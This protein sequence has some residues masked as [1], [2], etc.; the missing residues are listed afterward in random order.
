MAKPGRPRE[1]LSKISRMNRCECGCGRLTSLITVND[2]PRGL[3]K[4]EYRRFVRGHNAES[5]LSDVDLLM[6]RVAVGDE[7]SCWEWL[8]S[9]DAK[10]YGTTGGIRGL[11]GKAHRAVYQVF[12]GEIP[13][14]MCVLH[15]CDNPGCVNPNH[16]WLG[17]QLE[18]I[19]DRDRKGRGWWNR[20]QESRQAA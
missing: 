18:N 10:G 20:G 11:P 5:G 2:A 6:Y 8:G 16:L 12:E 15:R 3:V 14:G 9:K 4:G 19:A 1:P 7:E 13:E 17:T